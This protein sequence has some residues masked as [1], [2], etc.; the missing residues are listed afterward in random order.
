MR[1]DPKPAL[2]Q[3][4]RERRHIEVAALTNAA[5][6]AAQSDLARFAI[7]ALLH[8]QAPASY[9]AVGDEID[10][11]QIEKQLGPHAFP[12]VAGKELHF[13]LSSWAALQQGSFGIPEPSTMAPEITPD[14]VLVPVIAVTLS[15]VRL[16]QGG[17]FYDRALSRLR[18]AGQVT[19]IALAWD[20]QIA[21]A[22]AAD[23]WDA[24]MDWI[25]TPTRLVKCDNPR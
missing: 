22:L 2:R 19:A 13:Y 25:A 10:P 16:G 3:M 5:R 17:G 23:P 7:P 12:R 1:N 18:A 11:Q 24:P 6:A 20:S 15:G 14:I 8:C 21:D 4:F 9:A